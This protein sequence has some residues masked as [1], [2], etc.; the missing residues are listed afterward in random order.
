MDYERMTAPCGLDCFNCHL[1]LASENE[2]SMAV[3]EGLSKEYG[4]PVEKMHCRGCR[5]HDGLIPLHLYLF[6]DA[7]RCAA[8]ECSKEKNAKFCCDCDD[9]PCDNLHPYADK[10]AEVPHNTKVFN[11]CLIR[12]MGVEQWAEQKAADVKRVYFTC[13]WKLT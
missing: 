13:P 11:L 5:A 6:G 8:Y 4:V 2:E 1:Y 3:L 9:F 7:H 12:K 10:A